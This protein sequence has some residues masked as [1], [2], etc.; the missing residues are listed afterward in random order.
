M[1]SLNVISTGSLR[2]CPFS[3]DN[4]HLSTWKSIF[5]DPI[6]PIQYNPMTSTL[7][8]SLNIRV[9]KYGLIAW[10]KLFKLKNI[11]SKTI[12]KPKFSLL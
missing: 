1:H 7:M 12:T 9:K 11:K 4:K 5:G 2:W 3:M 6:L 10:E 8:Y